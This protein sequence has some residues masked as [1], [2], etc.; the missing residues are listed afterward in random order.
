M[1]TKALLLFLVL[2]DIV[3]AAIDF[4]RY[5]KAPIDKRKVVDLAFG[6]VLVFLAIALTMKELI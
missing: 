1:V 5:F 6:M 2:S 3:L 4:N